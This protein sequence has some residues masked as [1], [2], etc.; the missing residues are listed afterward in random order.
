MTEESKIEFVS[1]DTA[2]TAEATELLGVSH[3]RLSRLLNAEFI[4]AR[5]EKGKWVIDKESLK[6]FKK[7][8]DSA[9]NDKSTISE[10]VKKKLDDYEQKIRLSSRTNNL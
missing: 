2:T 3:T 7:F 1:V 4:T 10:I 5:K 6:Q 9:Y 8:R